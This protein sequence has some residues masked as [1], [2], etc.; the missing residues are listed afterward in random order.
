MRDNE[1]KLKWFPLFQ[2]KCHFRSY[3]FENLIS[4]TYQLIWEE[5]EVTEPPNSRTTLVWD[6]KPL[7]PLLE[8]RVIY[9]FYNKYF[10]ITF[11]YYILYSFSNFIPLSLFIYFSYFF[12][13]FMKNIVSKI[14]FWFQKILNIFEKI[15][16]QQR[17]F[18]MEG[19]S[20]F[21]YTWLGRA[22]GFKSPWEERE[23]P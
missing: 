19:V 14:F 13:I 3:I 7:F 23:A 15:K 10:F 12:F 17:C 4:E 22:R 1:V 9:L 6:I 8:L 18:R 5:L 16:L 11:K 20:L 21:T 2:N